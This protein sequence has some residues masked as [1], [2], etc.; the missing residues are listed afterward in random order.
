MTSNILKT[1][2]VSV[3]ALTAAMTAARA[4]ENTVIDNEFTTNIYGNH[5]EGNPGDRNPN[6]DLSGNTVK[7][8]KDAAYNS[9]EFTEIY[10]G[11]GYNSDAGISD[12]TTNNN[13]VTIEKENLQNTENN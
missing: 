2:A 3:I 1:A 5:A 12:P 4:G 6:A 10:G 9:G 11:I 13:T 7:F 8:E